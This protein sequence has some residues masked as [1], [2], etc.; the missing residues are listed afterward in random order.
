[1]NSSVDSRRHRVPTAS[2]VGLEDEPGGRDWSIFK[3]YCS[4]QFSFLGV[5]AD[6]D[7]C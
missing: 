6:Y 7:S 2:Q 3:L 4:L 1:L 5:S